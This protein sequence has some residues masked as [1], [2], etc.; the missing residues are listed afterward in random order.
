MF[1]L[2]II[3]LKGTLR[4]VG[5]INIDALHPAPV[6]RQQGF[7]GQQVVALNQQIV[8]V[9]FAVGLGELQQM[10]RDGC[11]FPHSLGFVHPIKKR[12]GYSG[13]WGLFE[14]E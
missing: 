2:I 11:G 4:V 10:V 3:M 5:W 9:G 12:H 13:S 8:G 7:Q 14:G 6:E 1:Q